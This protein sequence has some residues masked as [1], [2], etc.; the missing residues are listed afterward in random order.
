MSF[1]RQRRANNCAEIDYVNVRRVTDDRRQQV[2]QLTRQLDESVN[3]QL[4]ERCARRNFSEP[5]YQ[6]FKEFSESSEKVIVSNFSYDLEDLFKF[7]HEGENKSV[8]WDGQPIWDEEDSMVICDEESEDGENNFV[9][10]DVYEDEYLEE[11]DNLIVWYKKGVDSGPKIERI[12]RN[13]RKYSPESRSEDWRV[14]FTRQEEKTHSIGVLVS[15]GASGLGIER[16]QVRW[17][18]KTISQM[19]GLV[20]VC[21]GVR[22]IC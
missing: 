18:R 1:E 15:A 7:H 16:G 4:R 22:N 9:I 20:P 10:W 21:F 8:N 17:N 12:A 6:F 11:N 19:I 14:C 5:Q 2:E 3:K 13:G